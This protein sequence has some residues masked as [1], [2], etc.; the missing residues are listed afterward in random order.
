MGWLA[1]Q[2]ELSREATGQNVHAMEGMRGF[3]VFLVFLVHFVSLSAPWRPKDTLLASFALTIHTIGN[4][5]VDLFF[6]LSGY[7]IYGSLISR[8]QSFFS[9]MRRRVARIYPTFCVVFVAYLCLSFLYPIE[10]KI[11]TAN[12]AALVYLL[13]NFLL[14]PGIFPISPMITVAWSLSYEMFFYLLVP[15]AIFVLDMRAR[16]PWW[17]I[18]FFLIT[19]A[20]IAV[21]CAA[22]GGQIRLVM[23]IAGI[24]LFDA[25]KIRKIAPPQ[26]N[27]GL[28]ALIFG[29]IASAIPSFGPAAATLKNL[30]LA[31]AFFITC[32]SCFCVEGSKLA[33]AFTWAPLRRLGNMSYSYYLLHGLAL[34]AAFIVVAKL[35]PSTSHGI[36]L[37]LILLPL[38]FALTLMPSMVLF[39]LIERPFSLKPSSLTI[40]ASREQFGTNA[41]P[42]KR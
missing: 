33:R 21:Y 20:A 16:S 38:M 13:Q 7:L 34:K 40:L 36:L 32:Y 42:L 27:Y 18:R 35:I 28:F 41:P 24:L 31:T 5:G 9:F 8:Q 19:A 14:L 6:V 15:L 22:Y 1:R 29:L 3:A 2:F 10:S 37:V 4:C 39:I 26:D 30:I 25:L 12:D 11:P 23:F 17:R